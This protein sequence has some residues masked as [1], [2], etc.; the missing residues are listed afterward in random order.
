MDNERRPRPLNAEALWNRALRAL[1][2]RAQTI[3]ELREKLLRRAERPE[4]VE[5]IL[6]RLKEYGYLNDQRFAEGLATARLENEGLGKIRVL[7]DLRK[8]RVAPKL[9]ERVVDETYR[10]ADETRL[11][12]N[13][14]RRK[15]RKQPLETVLAEP[16]NLA[17][18]Y[19]RLRAAGFRAA[20]VHQVLHRLAKDREL[21]D[22]LAEAEE[23]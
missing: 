1:G 18:A 5:P 4:D 8:R 23:G 19:R 13:F 3:A 21:L 22:S 7:R 11:I 14:L 17:S 16:K 9:A 20:S 12:E 10:E 6:A 15:Y 2:S